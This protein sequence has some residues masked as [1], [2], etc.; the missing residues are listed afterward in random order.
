MTEK[1]DLQIL[2]LALCS[3]LA[4]FWI[5]IQIPWAIGSIFYIVVVLITLRC[6]RPVYI[7]LAAAWI[8]T[9]TIIG[10][11]LNPPSIEF[12]RSLT[13]HFLVLLVIWITAL[14]GS[15]YKKEQETR[16]LLASIIGATSDIVTAL[17]IDGKILSWNKAAEDVYGYNTQEVIGRSV[18]LL[19]PEEKQQEKWN[20]L[21]RI[22]QGE[23]IKHFRTVRKRKNGKLIHVSLSLSPIKDSVGNIVGISSIGRDITDRMLAEAREKDLNRRLEIEKLKLEEVLSLEEGL[24]TIFDFNKLIDFIVK[25]TSTVLEAN[26]CS[27]LLFDEDSNELTIKGQIGLEE[28]TLLNQRVLPE[29]SISKLVAKQGEPVLVKNIEEDRRFARES[30]PSYRT[31][32]FISVPIRLH[33]KLLGVINVADK[34]NDYKF[35]DI[36]LK[37]LAA[38]ARQVAIALENAKLYRELNFLAITDPLTNLNNYRY[39]TRSLDYEIERL[40]RYQGHL[41]LLMMDIDNFKSYNDTFGH[42]EGDQLLR[43]VSNVIG[44]NIRKIDIA[45]RYGGDEFVIILPETKLKDAVKTGEKIKEKISY[46]K[47]LSNVS[48][49]IGVA[50]FHKGMTRYDLVLSADVS[51]RQAKKAGKNRVYS[52]EAEKES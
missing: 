39:F 1:K 7:Y 33:N 36:D 31:K 10:F 14:S 29:D 13:N 12:F 38:I 45:C 48:L 25:R 4:F 9:L 44:K 15:E 47:L 26:R 37:V 11:T 35:H 27:L 22:L 23:Q 49:T 42:L 51:L 40:E 8:S 24:N 28:E 21:S 2:S 6:K 5:D 34:I 41:C 17:S 16:S 3:S 52:H 18:N 30:K 19:I 32:S 43:E 50:Q 20:L 46:L